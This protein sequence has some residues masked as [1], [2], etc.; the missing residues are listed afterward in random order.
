MPANLE[1]VV[2]RSGN[3]EILAV[4]VCKSRDGPHA[5]IVHLGKDGSLHLLHFAFHRDLRNQ[6]FPRVRDDFVC[7]APNLLQAEKIALAGYCRLISDANA[8]LR[9]IPYNLRYDEGTGFDPD[10]GDLI[11]PNGALGMGC[12]TFVLHVFRS[13]G[14]RLLDATAW[15]AGRS[16]DKERQEQLIAMLRRNPDPDYQEQATRVEN[17]EK[18][19]PRISPQEVA[20]ACLEDALPASFTHCEPNGRLIDALL[21][22][23]CPS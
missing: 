8:H 10:T 23:W 4:A 11:L 13:A 22:S 14:R 16:G 7:V 1:R 18:G 2:S 15:P 5:G 19:C 6:P 3:P 20:G 12:A 9:N 17:L 21:D